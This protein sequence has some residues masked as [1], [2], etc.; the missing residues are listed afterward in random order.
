MW[1]AGSDN[2]IR[3]WDIKAYFM[4][5]ELEERHTAPIKALLYV[6]D[7]RVWSGGLDRTFC[8]W[9]MPSSRPA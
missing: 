3:L 8:V 1:S 6:G 5:K 2:K 7:N 9:A 4:V